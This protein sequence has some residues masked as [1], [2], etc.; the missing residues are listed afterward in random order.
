MNQH[1]FH[2][3][4]RPPVVVF[5]T[6]LFIFFASG[7]SLLFVCLAIIAATSAQDVQ[8]ISENA[9]YADT[10]MPVDLGLALLV[11]LAIFMGSI[12][13][14]LLR[15]ACLYF[16]MGG[17]AGTLVKILWEGFA[18]SWLTGVSTLGPAGE[19]PPWVFWGLFAGALMGVCLY[20][21]RLTK[22]GVLS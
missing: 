13:L 11:S 2:Q 21:W 1:Q 20:S 7:S 6:S 16:F 17:M 18:K 14:F 12:K 3:S 8:Q 22:E 4:D 10:L 19:G 9:V 5:L 15:R